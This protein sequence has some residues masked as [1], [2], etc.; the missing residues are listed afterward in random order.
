MQTGRGKREKRVAGFDG[1]PGEN[2]FSLDDT[3][4]EAREIVFSGRIKSRHFRSL[5]PNQRAS[6]FAAGAAH[7]L[8]KL[9]DHFRGEFS[10]R[11]V[12]EEEKR[13]R[14]LNEDVVHAMIDDVPAD[15]RV[16]AHGHGDF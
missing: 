13:R 9:F 6:G 14:A 1:F 15:G 16:H 3:D 11:K 7:S 4:D 2:L 5:A 10:H 12:I 8:D